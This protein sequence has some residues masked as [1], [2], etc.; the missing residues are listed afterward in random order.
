[1]EV[2]SVILALLSM[3]L[4]FLSFVGLIFPKF[5]KEEDRKSVLKKFLLPAFIIFMFVGVIS[6]DS[7]IE[8]DEGLIINTNL[9]E[10]K[11]QESKEKL[12]TERNVKKEQE[13]KEN[14]NI[15]MEKIS[16]NGYFGCTDKEYFKKLVGYSAQ[17]NMSAVKQVLAKG[18]DANICI[19]FKSGESVLI[20]DTALLSGLV[21]LRI[22]GS[23]DE[24][25]TN[26]ETIKYE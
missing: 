1:M 19:M 20:V 26:L 15:G 17:K 3:L 22:K 4:F 7:L 10:N 16:S 6:P 8:K 2:L 18:V 12:N 5:I 9:I 14:K 23:I 21:R 25:W 11:E 24:Y 13:A